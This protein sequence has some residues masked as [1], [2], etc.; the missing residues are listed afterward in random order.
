M[1]SSRNLQILG[2]D[3]VYLG[4][5]I[6]GFISGDV[7]Q[8]NDPLDNKDCPSFDLHQDEKIQHPKTRG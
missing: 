8:D 2:H 5:A 6:D 3:G 4:V 7:R 1:V